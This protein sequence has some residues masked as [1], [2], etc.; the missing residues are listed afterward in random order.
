MSARVKKDRRR[1][2][3]R[4]DMQAPEPIPDTFENVIKS[5]VKPL[6]PEKR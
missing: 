4:V 3:N 2:K 5:L 6:P 1:K